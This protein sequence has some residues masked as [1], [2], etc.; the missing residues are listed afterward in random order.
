MRSP[1]IRSVHPNHTQTPA[2][3]QTMKP[4]IIIVGGSLLWGTVLFP[5]FDDIGYT[6]TKI[7]DKYRPT[8]ES[9]NTP[10]RYTLTVNE[11]SLIVFDTYTGAMTIG[12]AVQGAFDIIHLDKNFQRK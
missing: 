10:V 5:I 8:E 2:T 6:Y 11:G 3:S 1:T 7:R 12:H 4:A 9:T